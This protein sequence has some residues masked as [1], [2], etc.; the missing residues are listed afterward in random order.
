LDSSPL[1]RFT[2]QHRQIQLATYCLLY[3]RLP[4]AQ[5]L[6]IHPENGL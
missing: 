2:N 3:I 1:L 5:P 6:H 4:N